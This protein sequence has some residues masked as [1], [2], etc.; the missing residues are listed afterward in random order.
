MVCTLCGMQNACPT[1]RGPLCH[2]GKGL[3]AR[4]PLAGHRG[5]SARGDSVRFFAIYLSM[6]SCVGLCVCDMPMPS[7]SRALMLIVL[8]H[9]LAC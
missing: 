9:A 2:L 7:R 1:L 6:L 3:P 8:A 4:T 5:R